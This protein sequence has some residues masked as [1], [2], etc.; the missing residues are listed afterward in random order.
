MK[1]TIRNVDTRKDI[2]KALANE[3]QRQLVFMKKDI[4]LTEDE[5]RFFDQERN[6]TLTD[7]PAKTVKPNQMDYEKCNDCHFKV[8][9]FRIGKCPCFLCQIT[10]QTLEIDK[11]IEEMKSEKGIEKPE[12]I[13]TIKKGG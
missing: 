1:I 6:I 8:E 7:T 9:F 2:Y 11:C 5:N 3:L 12:A 13:I 10:G 4:S